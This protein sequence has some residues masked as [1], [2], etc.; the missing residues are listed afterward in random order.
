MAHRM[1][2]DD[3][4]QAVKKNTL[5]VLGIDPGEITMGKSLTDLGANSVDRMEIVTST[6]EDLGIK[7]PLM[8]FAGVSNIEGLVDVL[9]S[10]AR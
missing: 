3:V 5:E 10:H 9:S 1:T 2:K 6:M 8:S 4:F 7:I